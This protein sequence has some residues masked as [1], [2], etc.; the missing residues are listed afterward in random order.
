MGKREM[1]VLWSR[2]CTCRTVCKEDPGVS[3]DY[4]RSGLYLF[5]MRGKECVYKEAVNEWFRT[6]SKRTQI[7]NPQ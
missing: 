5:E 6:F 2:E 7:H 4:E 3:W 1:P